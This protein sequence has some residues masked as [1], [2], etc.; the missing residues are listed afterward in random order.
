MTDPSVSFSATGFS[1]AFPFG[2][3][4][5]EGGHFVVV[6]DALKRRQGVE[7]GDDAEAAFEVLR[8]RSSK[9]VGFAVQS[10]G[11]VTVL[12]HRASGLEIKG[13][14][15]SLLGAARHAFVGS[16][17]LHSVKEVAEQK[18]TLGDFPPNDATPDLL[19][20][21]QATSTALDDARKL[22]KSLSVALND[23]HAAVRAKERFLA[24][25]SHE[26]RTPLNGF[27]AMID[28]LRTSPLTEEQQE[29]L[30]TMDSCAQ[31]LLALVN[32]ILDLSKLEASGVELELAPMS[33]EETVE[34]TTNQFRA[35]AEAKGL[36]LEFHV[37]ASFSGPRMGDP[38][39]IGQVVANLLG[40][41]IKFTTEG[42]IAVDLAAVGETLGRVTITDTGI[43]IAPEAQSSL[44]DP[45]TQ[46]DS[47]VTRR[48]GGTG[49]GLAISSE[50]ARAMGGSLELTRSS[51]EGSTF[52]FT[53][54]AEPTKAETVA[55]GTSGADSPIAPEDLDCL[56]L[57]RI[58]I[59]EDNLMNQQIARR[60]V[61]KL[62]AVATVVGD[63]RA[64]VSTVR[65]REF[66]LVLMDL[67]MPVMAGT[68]AT[69]AIRALEVPW[70]NL[71]I[72]AFTA[73]AFEHDRE[74]ARSSGMDGFLEKPVRLNRMREV[75][76]EHLGPAS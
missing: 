35:K 40:N 6:G 73:G 71:P 57:S 22:G 23:A 65:E 64:A 47:S 60:L 48:F 21:M 29:Q 8:P 58:L 13:S 61:E 16:P 26:I 66:D 59:V 63:G 74:D 44:F 36:A 3:V 38:R 17:I 50:L 39:R 76:L 12:R 75:L 30:V 20:S 32:D 54:S 37:S 1:A 70:S 4:L 24:V 43:G 69:R 72:I 41:A 42:S 67:M 7:V 2:F 45:F 33:V 31:S 68:E 62:G 14:A 55:P 34:E 10:V 18:L 49:L 5:D 51:A 25:M 28:L 46:A 27:G 19:L 15:V 56:R 11:V 52:T 9:G 53:F